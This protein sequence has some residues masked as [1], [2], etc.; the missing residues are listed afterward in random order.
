MNGDGKY[1][2]PRPPSRLEKLEGTLSSV[3]DMVLALHALGM[4][5]GLF[6]HEELVKM[7]EL[8]SKARPKLKEFTIDEGI[9]AIVAAW[10]IETG[11]EPKGGGK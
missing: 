6:T 11:G 1:L 9:K 4:A 3:I 5:K 7:T 10:R 2:L 8:V